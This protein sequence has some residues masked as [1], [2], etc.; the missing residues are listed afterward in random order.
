MHFF[1]NEKIS[2]I[3]GIV[4]N[5]ENENVHNVVHSLFKKFQI[6]FFMLKDME[7]IQT[8]SNS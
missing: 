8:D 1:L 2:G 5:Y 4:F 3:S 6:F 7:K